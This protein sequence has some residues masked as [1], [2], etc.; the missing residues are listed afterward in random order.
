[1]LALEFKAGTAAQIDDLAD[2]Y[3]LAMKRN[4]MAIGHYDS[5]TVRYRFLTGFDIPA[6]TTLWLEEQLIGFYTLL[7]KPDHLWLHHLYIR[8]VHQGQ[9]IGSQI[10]ERVKQ[11]AQKKR[12]P[13]RLGTLNKSPANEFYRSHGFALTQHELNQNYYEFREAKAF[14]GYSTRRRV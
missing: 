3:E 10:I 8:P 6:T 14:Y 2:L 7:N 1:M 9:G 5:E 13:I 12:L 4:L 11:I